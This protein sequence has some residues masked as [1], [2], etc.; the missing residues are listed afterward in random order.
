M[1]EAPE[2][3]EA[4]MT[5]SITQHKNTLEISETQKKKAK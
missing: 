5:R 2:L 4:A 1:A 3:S